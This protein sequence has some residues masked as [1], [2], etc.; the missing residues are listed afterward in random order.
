[1]ARLPGKR[2]LNVSFSG[3]ESQIVPSSSR[4]LPEELLLSHEPGSRMLLPSEKE[5]RPV[6]LSLLCFARVS[7]LL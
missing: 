7:P 1:M 5:K 6:V 2:K 3:S 4:Y